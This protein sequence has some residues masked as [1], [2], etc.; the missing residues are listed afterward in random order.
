MRNE[1]ATFNLVTSLNL[2][3]SKSESERTTPVADQSKFNSKF[4]KIK[5]TR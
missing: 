3:K 2:T 5:F 4:A 1:T